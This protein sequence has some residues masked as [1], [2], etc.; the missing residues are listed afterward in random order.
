MKMIKLIG[1]MAI[2]T[3]ATSAH[4]VSF[5]IDSFDAPGSDSIAE[6]GANSTTTTTSASILGGSRDITLSAPNNGDPITGGHIDWTTGGAQDFLV[7]NNDSGV[8][9]SVTVVWNNFTDID[10]TVGGIN[11]FLTVRILDIDLSTAVQFILDDGAN[12]FS[13]GPQL[14]GGPGTFQ[15]ALSDF[16]GVDATSVDSLTMVLTGA[17]AWDGVFDL[18]ETNT[19][20]VP[21]P[22]PMALMGLGLVGLGLLRRKAA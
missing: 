18:V 2:L 3:M 4:A 21:A 8:K 1:A 20:F 17:T 6:G 19:R 16:S 13:V 7:V 5:V 12:S 10:F 9:G 15:V 22:A 11:D 14:F